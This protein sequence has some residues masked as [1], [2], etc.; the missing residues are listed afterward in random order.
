MPKVIFRLANALLLALFPAVQL[1]AQE[2]ADTVWIQIS[3]TVVDWL[4]GDPLPRAQLEIPGLQVSLVTDD[5]GRFEFPPLPQG[6]HRLIVRK[7]GYRTA[8]GDLA[9]ENPGSFAIRLRDE[10]LDESEL[11]NL[12]GTVTD[13]DLDRPVESAEVRLEPGTEVRGTD[14]RGQF[15]F[16]NIPPGDYVLR[17]KALGYAEKEYPFTILDGRTMDV[18]IELSTEPIPLEGITVTA[19]SRFL[20]SAGFFR[21]E[22]KGYDGRQWGRDQIEAANVIF[23]EDLVTLV[24][25]IQATRNRLGQRELMG[26]GRCRLKLYVDDVLLEDFDLANLDPDL[27]EA[28]EVYHGGGDKIPLEYGMKPNH[29]GVILVWLKH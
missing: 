17:V 21:R 25:G 9:V 18:G 4:S 27:I 6:T 11:G 1:S 23:V 16:M 5:G 15:D 14:R 20:E 28:M 2:P 24:P 12:V 13:A 19:R 7:L 29:C 26:R 10:D 8:D 22:G 3:G